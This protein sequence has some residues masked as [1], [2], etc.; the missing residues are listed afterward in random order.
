MF[1]TVNPNLRPGPLIRSS[2]MAW[3]SA[4]CAASACCARLVTYATVCTGA[5]PPR[6]VWRAPP[7]A[8]TAATAITRAVPAAAA[9]RM[10][11]RRWR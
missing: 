2:S 3:P 4:A 8:T 10:A 5:L 11:M 6:G 9:V 1:R 7:T